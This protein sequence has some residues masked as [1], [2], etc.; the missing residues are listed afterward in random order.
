[1]SLIIINN[2][3]YCVCYSC[4]QTWVMM[5]FVTWGR[6]VITCPTLY[7]L[8]L[9]HFP[10][11]LS[12]SKVRPNILAYLVY[13][14]ISS[15]PPP[16]LARTRFAERH[17]VAKLFQSLVWHVNYLTKCRFLEIFA[18][19]DVRS[20]ENVSRDRLIPTTVTWRHGVI[21]RIGKTLKTTKYEPR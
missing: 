11:I 15:T 9:P 13:T 4:L 6:C 14:S 21:I 5:T 12:T 10:L 7:V 19:F 16:I 20:A 1:M 8:S 18:V 17:K 3:V 2:I